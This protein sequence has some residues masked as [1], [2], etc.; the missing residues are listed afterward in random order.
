MKFLV[1]NL[2]YCLGKT[3]KSAWA[4][5]RI[6]IPISILIRLIQQT[7]LL[8]YLSD[9]LSPIM[10]LVGL[11]AETAL[12]WITALVV[13]IYGGLLSLFSIYPS[14]TAPLTSA[15]MTILLTMI[16]IAHTFPIEL[17]ITRKT[18]IKIIV[19]FCIRFGFGILAGFLLSK[20]YTLF[21]LLENPVG[22][23]NFITVK[24]TSWQAWVF[25]ELKNYVIIICI[26]FTLVSLIRILEL[27][28]LLQWMNKIML[29]LL[30][31]LG[32]SQTMLP[33]TIIGL[34]MGIAYG[35]GLIIE[36]VKNP[37]VKAK[38]I[39]YA[40]T[41][42]GL[43][44]SIFEDTILMLSMG[45]HWSGVIVFRFVFAFAITFIIMRL[46]Q[47]MPEEKFNKLFMTKQFCKHKLSQTQTT[48]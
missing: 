45:G 40:M 34:S 38:D 18:G 44:H 5:F 28:G 47:N 37:K 15:Q 46:T 24:D 19:S 7:A 23:T 43:F 13:N 16:L 48:I 10:Q 1:S 32:I 6:M 11:P 29:P 35:G 27:C 2:Q 30:S 14:L 3:A 21:H 36:E 20:I 42:M 12:V 26:I 41:L 9:I 4:L 31:W 8:P 39:F 17:G 33:L 25:N 22:I